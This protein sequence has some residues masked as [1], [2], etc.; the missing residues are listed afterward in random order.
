[1][2]PINLIDPF[3]LFTQEDIDYLTKHNPY[4]IDPWAPDDAWHYENPW[5]PPRDWGLDPWH[6]VEYPPVFDLVPDLTY[7]GCMNKCIADVLGYEIGSQ[8]ATSGGTILAEGVGWTL[9]TKIIPG[10]SW[11]STALSVIQGFMCHKECSERDCGN[12]IAP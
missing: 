8:I 6:P 1:V 5:N 3:G 2:N 9:G 4:I 11:G 10:L 7:E 12:K